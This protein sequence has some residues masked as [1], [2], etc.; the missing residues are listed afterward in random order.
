M[1]TS[2]APCLDPPSVDGV[3]L[4]SDA[5]GCTCGPVAIAAALEVSLDAVREAVEQSGP[6]R[7]WMGVRDVKAALERLCA[8]PA[9]TWSKPVE[10]VHPYYLGT[11]LAEL[12]ARDST[13][14]V[15]LRFTG[16]WDGVPR[17]AASYRH[18]IAYR[19]AWLRE[20]SWM[21]A[22]PHGPGIVCDANNGVTVGR[23]DIAI[24][25]P[26]NRWVHRVLMHLLPER[27]DEHVA[28][29]WAAEVGG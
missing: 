19:R 7:G 27:G 14:L 8:T 10:R 18:L 15:M 24:W 1:L 13:L 5:W 22:G 20:P 28:I 29:D 17:A 21:G 9:R 12:G 16:P 4:A 2:G 6:F 11:P 3:Q 26:W 23:P 25:Y